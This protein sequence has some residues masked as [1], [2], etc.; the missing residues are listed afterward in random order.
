MTVEQ[1]DALLLTE[2]DEHL[3]FKEA[4]QEF[5][6]EKLRK[7]CC[8][9]ANERGGK[10][11]LGVSRT[12]P[13]RVVGTAAFRDLVNR[14]SDLVQVLHL[15]IDAEEISHPDG[16]VVVFDVP[17][18]LIGVPLRYDG[19]YWMRAGESL[20]P[21]T[22]DVLKRIFEETAVEVTAAP[23]DGSP[24]GLVSAAGMEELRKLMV[25]AGAAPDLLRQGDVDLLCALGGVSGDGRLLVAGLLLAGKPDTI[26]SVVPHA[27]WQFRRMKSDTEY[28][29]V[30]DGYDSIPVALRRLR[31]LV[32]TNN[33]IVTIPGWLV[34]PEFPRYPMLALRELIV[35]AFAHR[36]YRAPGAV[37]L[38]LYPDR[39]ELSNPGGFV[40][41]VTPDNILHHPSV[42]RNPALFSALTRI[43]LANASN[44]GVPRVYR[45]LL[46]EGKEPPVYWTSGQAIRVT[47][48][49]QEAR[50]EFLQLVK[51]NPGLDIDDLLVLHYLTRHREVTVRTAATICQRP[52]EVARET[53]GRLVTQWRLL[54]PCGVGKGRYYRLSRSAYGR[55]VGVLGYDV[56]SRLALENARARVLEALLRRP[57]SNA[58]VREIT[59]MS[60][61]QALRLMQALERNGQAKLDG[62]GRASRWVHTGSRA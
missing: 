56:D 50:R 61:P 52:D 42:P 32:G 5:S 54:E 20:T 59:Q 8:A 57:L 27:Q 39:L 44:L 10:L 16:R 41:G 26:R 35:N 15:R 12:R 19:V 53:L 13:R 60:R 29:Q 18:R 6:V 24:A 14:R 55:L 2:E 62:R 1:L 37:V 49:G 40:G 38:K 22:E 21:M 23:I 46:S 51:E 7:Y 31:E 30:E 36:D 11:I 9:L 28:D 4:R 3:E 25:E 58:D 33:P 47:V 48:K 43:R 34:H 17:S 45:D